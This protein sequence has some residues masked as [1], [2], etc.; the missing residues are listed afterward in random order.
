MI[1]QT[2]E[3]GSPL[4]TDGAVAREGMKVW[5]DPVEA[6]NEPVKM[7]LVTVRHPGLPGGEWPFLVTRA[8][9]PSHATWWRGAV[10]S[11]L[12]AALLAAG[13]DGAA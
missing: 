6:A 7:R 4:T 5:I 2:A 10:Y 1:I 3:D 8:A 9:S 12:D 13:K 11:T